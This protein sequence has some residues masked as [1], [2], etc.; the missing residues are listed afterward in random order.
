MAVSFREAI[1]ARSQLTFYG[2][3]WVVRSHEK[4]V[5]GQMIDESISIYGFHTSSEPRKKP[6]WLGY[7]GDNT[8]QLYRDYNEPL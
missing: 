5:D 1:I 7:I 2:V 6:C 3:R 8:T 4:F